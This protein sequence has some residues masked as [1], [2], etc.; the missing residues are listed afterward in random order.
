MAT[1]YRKVTHLFHQI[2]DQVHSRFDRVL[3][4]EARFQMHSHFQWSKAPLRSAFLQAITSA[5]SKSEFDHANQILR[6][7]I[8]VLVYTM[9]RLSSYRSVTYS[10]VAS[11]LWNRP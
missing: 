5:A 3:A 7:K 8:G 1:V 9:S 11:L 6:L 10:M 2:F 4:S